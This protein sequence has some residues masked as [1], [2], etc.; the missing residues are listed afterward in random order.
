MRND[1]LKPDLFVVS[2]IRNRMPGVYAFL[3]TFL[4]IPVNAA[5][6]LPSE[7]LTTGARVAPNLLFILDD[8]GSMGYNYMPDSVPAISGDNVA[9]RAYTRNT[10]YYNPAINYR[11]WTLPDGSLMTAGTEYNRVMTDSDYVT[12]A[13][14]GVGAISTTSAIANLS[15]SVQEFFV[16]RN[17]SNTSETYLS[18]AANY[19]RYQLLTDGRVIRSIYGQLTGNNPNYNLGL[20][21]SGCLATIGNGWRECTRVTPT[22]RTEEEERRNFAIWYSYHR[23]RMKAAKAGVSAVFNELSGDIRVGFRTI[24]RK[25]GASTA[26]NSPKFST[27]IPVA[28]NDGLFA[29]LPAATGGVAIDN[30]TKWYERLYETKGSDGTPLHGALQGAG[31]YFSSDSAAGPYGP[32]VKADQLACRQNFTILTTDGFWNDSA[33]YVSKAGNADGTAGSKI[34]G[35][36][37]QSYTYL[38]IDPYKDGHGALV[39]ND[40]SNVDA[41]LAD[42]A[43]YYW[44]NDLRSDLS[45]IVPTSSGN[46]AFWQHMVTF[47]ISIGMSGTVDQKSVAEVHQKGQA[48]V[49]GVAGWPKP[50]SNQNTT[51]DDLFHAAVNGRGEFVSAA[52]PGMFTSGLKAALTSITERTGSFS[53]VGANST[54]LDAGTQ[55]FQASYVSGA[56]TGQVVAYP[57]VGGKVNPTASWRASEGVPAQNRK[58]F[59]RSNAGGVTFPDGLTSAQLQA[60]TRTGVTNY[61]VTGADNASYIAGIRSLETQN[62]GALRN[63]K[64]LLGDVVNS[65]PAFV[66]DT[67]VLFVGANDGMLHAINAADGRELFAFIPGAIDWSDLGT[68][69]RP[70]YSHRYFVDG[71]VVV[72]NRTQT[73]GKNILIGALGKGGK[74]IYSLDVSRPSA[75]GASDVKWEVS[76]ANGNM[77]LV[78]S[79]PI[80]AKLNNGVD[81]VI[82]ANGINSTNGRAVLLIFNLETGALIREIDTGVGAAVNDGKDSNGLSSPIGWD[83]DGSGTVDYVYSGDMRGN[84]WKFDLR[85]ATTS[86]WGVS[87]DAPLFQ[88]KNSSGQSQPIVGGITIAMHPR[89]F[90]TWVFFGT[91]RL[92]TEGDMTSDTQQSLYGFVDDGTVLSRSGANANLTARTVVV[93]GSS[94]GFPVRS[95]EAKSVL[96]TQSKGW[97][98]DLELADRPNSREK[99]GERVVSDP[100]L[101]GD[102]LLVS[103]LIPTA[104]ACQADGRGYLNALD[105]FTGTSTGPSLFDLNANGKFDDEILQSGNDKLPIGSVDLGVGMPTLAELLRG[106]AVLGGSS[107]N[108][109]NVGIR[110]ARNVGRVSWREIL[111]N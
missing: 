31:E 58:V 71:P 20:S 45:N 4:A 69:S 98:L 2:A 74:G 94:S 32:A 63:R 67:G 38:P 76:D 109:A 19:Y 77:G 87:G 89:T 11:P 42:V 26:A 1:K 99:V 24:W 49:K 92:L 111:D 70:D 90:K 29:D 53:N 66:K 88:A 39:V 22:G 44:K 35:P 33:N 73:P 103:S 13:G 110:E 46:P 105:A 23:T 30:K 56:W 57:V 96:P 6:T 52:D 75:F 59:T 37:D 55:L 3:F 41:T 61:P 21:N 9:S 107:G 51:I 27:P 83:A 18:A 47:G 34:S 81:A 28:H 8:S 100:Q 91:G 15:N 64:S 43:M 36:N 5:I 97:Y 93:K 72:S 101:Y 14:T 102:V 95:F 84:L 60:L 78:Q 80:I 10:V 62:G 104:N 16:P 48:T 86:T 54:S 25:N 7:P 108:I 50:V 82:V 85:A 40:I 68:L 17:L 12:Y 65:S 79:K 106:I